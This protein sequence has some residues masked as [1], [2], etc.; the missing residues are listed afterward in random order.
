MESM[1]LLETYF[2]Y[3]HFIAFTYDIFTI[4]AKLQFLFNLLLIYFVIQI[5]IKIQ[6]C[7]LYINCRNKL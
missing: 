7:H 3:L 1:A 4:S 6:I 5:T 2:Y